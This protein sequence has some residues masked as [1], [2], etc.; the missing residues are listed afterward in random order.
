MWS[1]E[2]RKWGRYPAA[3]SRMWLFRLGKR[4]WNCACNISL[5]VISS[6]DGAFPREA[7]ITERNF[8]WKI[9]GAMFLRRLWRLTNL[10]MYSLPFTLK[11]FAHLPWL[12]LVLWTTTKPV[13]ISAG[14]WCSWE[15]RT[16]SHCTYVLWSTSVYYSRW[17]AFWNQAS[18]EYARCIPNETAQYNSM[19]ETIMLFRGTVLIISVIKSEP[20]TATSTDHT[21]HCLSFLSSSAHTSNYLHLWLF[22][23]IYFIAIFCLPSPSC[24]V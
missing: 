17:G 5:S 14:Y 7:S 1:V 11:R 16:W 21:F 18:I 4:G 20:Y 9:N 6:G 22:F 8:S 12:R 13:E 15:H 24:I 2:F 10:D 19:Y 23:P 3:L